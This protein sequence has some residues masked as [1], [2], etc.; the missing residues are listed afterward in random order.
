MTPQLVSVFARR[1][2][3]YR[4]RLRFSDGK[5]GRRGSR[6]PILGRVSNRCATRC[7]SSSSGWDPELRTLVWPN[8]ADLAPETLYEMASASH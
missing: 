8:G 1:P 3:P 4:I 7:G 6:S 2:A 5:R